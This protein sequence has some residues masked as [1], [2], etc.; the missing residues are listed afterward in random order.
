MVTRFLLLWIQAPG[1]HIQ[2][3]S[4]S[5]SI[6]P[7]VFHKRGIIS[8]HFGFLSTWTDQEKKDCFL[9]E[10]AHLHST[11]LASCP[12][13][14]VTEKDKKGKYGET[15]ISEDRWSLCVF[16]PGTEAKSDS[17][18]KEKK[19]KKKEEA[20][21]VKISAWR[22]KDTM[23]AETCRSKEVWFLHRVKS[24]SYENLHVEQGAAA[25]TAQQGLKGERQGWS[26]L[27]CQQPRSLL[28]G[29]IS[30]PYEGGG[31]PHLQTNAPS[32]C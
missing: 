20:K 24:R 4:P 22:E 26:P 18:E 21:S 2:G 3:M 28:E 31:C 11:S 29:G 23:K 13:G 8:L 14:L 16:H 30:L 17:G 19:R 1:P 7:L 32:T 10:S 9:P 5:K 12:R 15:G 27:C 25:G 6:F